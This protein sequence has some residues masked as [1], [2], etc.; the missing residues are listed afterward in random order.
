MSQTLP[1]PENIPLS[2]IL[3]D[4]PILLMGAGP[5]PIPHA[6]AQ[7]N[8]VVI[9]HL[10]SAMDA[11]V[12]RVKEMARYV[13]QTK[14][15]HVLGISGPASAGM[16]MA[17]TSV[18]W[19]GRKVL[20]LKNGTFSNRF[21]E[22]A[23]AIGAEVDILEHDQHRPFTL[24]EVK[25]ALSENAYDVVTMAQGETSCGIE[26]IHLEEITK[27][28]KKE[29]ILSI[30][31]AVCTL[32]C[33][34]FYMDEW[35]IDIA[36]TGGQ[37]GLSSIPGVS[38]IAFSEHAWNT[39]E[40][41]KTKI[42]QWVLNPL[43]ATRF[44]HH[45]EYHYTA[46]VPGILALHE[47]LRLI[48]I[49][50]LEKRYQRHYKSSKAIQLGLEAMGLELYIPE[51]YR[52]KTVIAISLPETIDSYKLRQYMIDQHRVDISGAFGLPI[53][54]IGQMGDQCLE[55]NSLR[56]LY[57]FGSACSHLGLKV[58]ISEGMV[59]LEN[60]LKTSRIRRF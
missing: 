52:L 18:L 13:F 40:N 50:T 53:V 26:N 7:A 1:P 46:P 15:E 33:L 45:K 2:D 39:I 60:Y 59:A 11:V 8:G 41:R 12:A 23:E 35:G 31:D 20:I 43:K 27:Y 42:P 5:V 48:T 10:G 24:E 9:N 44:W 30:V 14:S 58:K 16:E 49:E 29:N 28:L 38:L 22:M 34:P 32:S 37:K 17:I 19:P 36:I 6:V 54:R 47:A 3:P 21:A 4:R 56:T 51:E 55:V 57:A 25:Q